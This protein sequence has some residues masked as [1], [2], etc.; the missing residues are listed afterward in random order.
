MLNTVKEVVEKYTITTSTTGERWRIDLPYDRMLCM[1]NEIFQLK[2]TPCE[3]LRF[4]PF[5][6]NIKISGSPPEFEFEEYMFFVEFRDK[7][8]ETDKEIFFKECCKPF[9]TI[10]SEPY[11]DSPE[12]QF[13]LCEYGNEVYFAQCL[14]KY[15]SYLKNEALVKMHKRVENVFN[16]AKE[17]LYFGCICF[18]VHCR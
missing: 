13:F 1:L 8:S 15:M 14:N 17:N 10:Y 16:V 11:P 9:D 7:V 3:Y 5:Y 12:N 2:K 4:T 18:E 6:E